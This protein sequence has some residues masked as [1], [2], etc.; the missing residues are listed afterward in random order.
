[1]LHAPLL[2]A[3]SS[4]GLYASFQLKFENP[5]TD[6]L[7]PDLRTEIGIPETSVEIAAL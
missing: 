7:V 5:L 1:M 3:V 4:L 2:V 6:N